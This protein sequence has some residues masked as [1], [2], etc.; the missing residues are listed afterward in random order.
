M[1]HVGMFPLD[2]VKVSSYKIIPPNSLNPSWKVQ[3]LEIYV[4]GLVMVGK[5]RMGDRL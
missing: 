1:E 3:E 5:C 2:T 4:E